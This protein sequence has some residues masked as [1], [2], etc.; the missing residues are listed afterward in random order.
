[1]DRAKA[2]T[3]QR[4]VW[5]A[6][7]LAAFAVER[8]I[9]ALR[10][11]M[12]IC[13]GSDSAVQMIEDRI[14]QWEFYGEGL[15]EQILKYG[16]LKSSQ[17]DM[18]ALIKSELTDE[19]IQYS[20]VFPD[21]HGD[22]KGVEFNLERTDRYREYVKENADMV[23]KLKLNRYQ[24]RSIQNFINSKRSVAE[25]RNAVVAETGTDLSFERLI[26]YLEML[27]ELNWVEY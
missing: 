18:E 10:S 6:F 13:S 2:K 9:G 17:L 25:I 8:E 7:N 26:G 24:Q 20:K 4:D 3:F 27:K 16:T 23:K 19:E 5:K 22:V 14:K 12:E 1:V 15:E 21:Y 11:L